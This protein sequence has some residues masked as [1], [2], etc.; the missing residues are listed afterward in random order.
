M[1][2]HTQTTVVQIQAQIDIEAAMVNLK[3]IVENIQRSVDSIRSQ[4][5]SGNAYDGDVRMCS[6]RL[7]S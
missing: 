5:E 2:W 1:A 7:R 6:I 4:R 3:D